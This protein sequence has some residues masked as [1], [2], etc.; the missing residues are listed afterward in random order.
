MMSLLV[1]GSAHTAKWTA[2]IPVS[3]RRGVD[4][5]RSFETLN[6]LNSA[7]ASGEL[8]RRG[9]PQTEPQA[10]RLKVAVDGGMGAEQ[11]KFV[12]PICGKSYTY[13]LAYDRHIIAA[14]GEQLALSAVVLNWAQT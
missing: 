9:S 10:K 8:Q 14:H 5:P 1:T 11:G 4:I 6:L 12:C 3:L 13:K 2:L 7:E